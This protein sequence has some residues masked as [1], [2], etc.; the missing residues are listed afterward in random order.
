MGPTRSSRRLRSGEVNYDVRSL[1]LRSTRRSR[2]L[3]MHASGATVSD[4]LLELLESFTEA[5][6]AT[7]YDAPLSRNFETSGEESN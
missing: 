2:V 5:C 1:E 4:A 6:V 3:S 7:G